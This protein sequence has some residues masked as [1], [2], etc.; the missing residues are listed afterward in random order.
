MHIKQCTDLVFHVIKK[1]QLRCIGLKN[2]VN[3]LLFKKHGSKIQ[4]TEYSIYDTIKEDSNNNNV[5]NI[6]KNKANVNC[7]LSV[8][9]IK[10]IG[11]TFSSIKFNI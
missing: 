3:I 9:N 4:N 5:P 11:L 2:G 6:I 1:Y 7:L 8:E 10:G